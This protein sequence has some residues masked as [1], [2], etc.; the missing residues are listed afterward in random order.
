[1][2]INIFANAICASGVT[3]FLTQLSDC[4][5]RITQN[6][7]TIEYI[8]VPPSSARAQHMRLVPPPKSTRLLHEASHI[9]FSA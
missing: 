6:C 5:I 8:R 1:M 2:Y 3:G 7:F 4:C 9:H